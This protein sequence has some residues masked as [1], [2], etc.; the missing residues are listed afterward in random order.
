MGGGAQFSRVVMRWVAWEWFAVGIGYGGIL[1]GGDVCCVC[2]CVRMCVC[3][4]EC[5]G[6]VWGR[7]MSKPRSES[8]RI[9]GLR[10]VAATWVLWQSRGSGIRCRTKEGEDGF[11]GET[12]G[13]GACGGCH[14]WWIRR[15]PMDC[16]LIK[17]E[18]RVASL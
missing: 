12:T 13:F 9:T 17:L 1:V 3:E 5:V 4:C 16:T 15:D 10:N 14:G 6:N 11:V 18:M 2:V 8:V 7:G